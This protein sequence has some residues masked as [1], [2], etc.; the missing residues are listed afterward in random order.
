M[1]VFALSRKLSQN[2][3]PHL[4]NIIFFT[5]RKLWVRND[6][7]S[8]SALKNL[9]RCY[10]CYNVRGNG[11]SS[12]ISAKNQKKEMCGDFRDNLREKTK[13]LKI[14]SKWTKSQIFEKMVKNIFLS[15]RVAFDQIRFEPLLWQQIVKKDPCKLLKWLIWITNLV[16]LVLS[17]M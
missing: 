6:P 5:F 9:P 13:V 4:H 14:S 10:F 11:K 12:V 2:S 16:L 1:F 7:M 17:C 15:T 8:M 3:V